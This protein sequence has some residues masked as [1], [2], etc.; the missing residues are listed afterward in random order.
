MRT[1]ASS[2]FFAGVFCISSAAQQPYEQI[3]EKNLKADVNFL[4][5]EDLAGRKTTSH[6]ARIAASYIA[7]EFLR[8][9]L[10]PLGDDNSYF[11]KYDLTLASQD[12]ANTSFTVRSAAQ[13][14]S[15]QLGHDF[16]LTWITQ[17]TNP[18][19]ATGPLVFLGYGVKAPE[20]NY[21]DLAGVDLHG[22]IVVILMH[23]P[24]ESD[25]A[26]K[27]KGRWH[28]YHAYD[29]YKYEDIRQ[30]GA[31]G[32]LEVIEKHQ[33]R[34]PSVSSAPRQD[35]FPDAIYSLPGYWDL[36]V[37][38]ITEDV[39]NELLQSSG[40]TVDGLRKAIDSHLTP[41]SFQLS[42]ISATLKKS[43][44]NRKV[45]EAR[46]VVGVLEGS[47]PKLKDQY[48][49]VS[50]HYDHLGVVQGRTQFGAD[51]NASGV[52]A[53]LEIARA[54]AENPVKPKRSIL[55][56]SFDSEEAGLL[57]SFYYGR[58]PLLPLDKAAAVLNMDM[59]GRN[60][61]T[62]TWNV[63][64]EFTAQSVNLVGTL[65]S[66]TLRSIAQQQNKKLS[67]NLDFKTD[68]EDKEEWFA[69]SD[70]YVFATHGIPSILFNTGEHPDYHTE[71]DTWDR[72]N[73][74]KLEKISRLVFLVADDVANRDLRPEFDAH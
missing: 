4:S 58:H 44:T 34:P 70:Q 35:W 13:E 67:L 38:E 22:K 28:T 3:K 21:D 7:S 46:N 69:R 50:A 23:E 5:S 74:P 33:H 54:F 65:Y 52:A 18:T 11:Q 14:K 64:P 36:P 30:A 6:E 63:T 45:V 27:F 1:F 25:P 19:T 43:Y 62:A 32:I 42:G 2:L 55:F 8:L 20:Y 39:A 47:D 9:G 61:N 56:I 10:K 66:P 71:N 29:Q 40:K 48:V 17:T 73:Y 24:Q 12:D 26:S 31:V 68:S 49:I 60:E 15:Y 59:V 16:D 53:L 41:Q 72:L 51:D 37:F 57:G